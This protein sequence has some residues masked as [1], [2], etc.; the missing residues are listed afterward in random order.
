MS[1]TR[2]RAAVVRPT[3]CDDAAAGFAI[4]RGEADRA[5]ARR[6]SARGAP[7]GR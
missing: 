5:T 4:D 1:W 6:D 2:G 3:S 7:F